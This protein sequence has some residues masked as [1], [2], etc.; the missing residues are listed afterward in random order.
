MNFAPGLYLVNSSFRTR[1]HFRGW[2]SNYLL[3]HV[4]V[5]LPRHVVGRS[6]DDLLLFLFLRRSDDDG[7]SVRRSNGAAHRKLLRTPDVDRTFRQN[8]ERALT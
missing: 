1:H 7:L 6:N 2:N 8:L 3:S 4:V 5:F